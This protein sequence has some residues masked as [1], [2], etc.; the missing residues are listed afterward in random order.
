MR[1]LPAKDFEYTGQNSARL[2]QG[3]KL[4]LHKAMKGHEVIQSHAKVIQSGEHIDESKD[5]AIIA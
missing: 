3:D 4:V 1:T 2:R 5:V